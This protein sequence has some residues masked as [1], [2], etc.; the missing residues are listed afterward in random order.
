M[1]PVTPHLRPF[2]DASGVAPHNEPKQHQHDEQDDPDDDADDGH[3][4]PGPG[5]RFL[6]GS[7]GRRLVFELLPLQVADLFQ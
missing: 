7:D 3:E 5:H 4:P 1:A 2:T 6:L